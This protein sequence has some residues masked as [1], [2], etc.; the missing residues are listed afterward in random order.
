MTWF[1]IKT[2][3]PCR[4][5]S[6]PVRTR[7]GVSKNCPKNVAMPSL[8][9]T[10]RTAQGP[11]HPLWTTVSLTLANAHP[12]DYQNLMS[13]WIPLMQLLPMMDLIRACVLLLSIQ[14]YSYKYDFSANLMKYCLHCRP[15]QIY[16]H[17]NRHR[18]RNPNLP[19]IYAC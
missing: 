15:R 5:C 1:P 10:T 19:S 17:Q 9:N 13:Q 4:A 11:R 6:G 2:S 3:P 14:T 18:S 7:D 16:H 8:A 12:W